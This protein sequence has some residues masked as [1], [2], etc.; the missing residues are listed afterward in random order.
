MPL[1]VGFIWIAKQ[2]SVGTR[3]SLK[4]LACL[5]SLPQKKKPGLRSGAREKTDVTERGWE[6]RSSCKQLRFSVSANTLEQCHMAPSH[7]ARHIL[8]S[9]LCEQSHLQFN[10]EAKV[11][12]NCNNLQVNS[13]WRAEDKSEHS[14]VNIQSCIINCSSVFPIHWECWITAPCVR[15]IQATWTHNCWGRSVR[16]I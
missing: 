7:E 13:R 14:S 8:P 6:R 4:R 11:L 2:L 15:A 3:H 5:V 9:V 12:L 1:H 10:L 16:K